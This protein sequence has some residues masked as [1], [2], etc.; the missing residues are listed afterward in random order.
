MKIVFNG[1]EYELNHERNNACTLND[2]L[3][4][5]NLIKG[6]PVEQ[7]VVAVNQSLV[8]KSD[9]KSLTIKDGDQIEMLTAVVGG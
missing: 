7:A 9:Y 8:H 5:K 3:S 4:K 6:V 2:V 1:Q